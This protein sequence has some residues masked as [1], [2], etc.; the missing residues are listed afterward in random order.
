MNKEKLIKLLSTTLITARDIEILKQSPLLFDY[1]INKNK[2]NIHA[3]TIVSDNKKFFVLI[4]E[5]VYCIDV[6]LD[7]DNISYDLIGDMYKI[8]PEILDCDDKKLM[9]NFYGQ[10]LGITG[11]IISLDTF[12]AEQSQDGI[13]ANVLS[14][15]HLM[16]ANTLPSEYDLP[17]RRYTYYKDLDDNK[18]IK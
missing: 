3:K 7:E 17:R 12:N 1:L 13:I 18:F 2:K 15:N 16:D 5:N 9:V 4:D 14:S 6:C 8:T 11:D 10:A